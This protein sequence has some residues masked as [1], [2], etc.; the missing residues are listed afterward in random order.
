LHIAYLDV[1]TSGLLRDPEARVVE[2][3]LSVWDGDKEIFR[4]ESLVSGKGPIPEEVSRINGITTEMTVGC[5]TF[6]E[7]YGEWKE[8][9]KKA[10]VVAHNLSFDLGMI[11]RDLIRQ[12]E[13]PLGNPGID[14]LALFRR[15]KPDL[16]SYKLTELVRIMGVLHENPHRAMGDVDAMRG[17]LTRLFEKSLSTHDEG[18]LRMWCGWGGTSAHRYQ[19]DLLSWARDRDMS[20]MIE[21]NF[22]GGLLSWGCVEGKVVSFNGESVLVDTGGNRSVLSLED[23][24]AVYLA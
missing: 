23:V 6:R 22:P 1:E 17:I 2:W 10:I 7:L 21:R 14:S 8:H 9:L 4:G 16:S 24:M 19:R 18:V 15:M 5:P 13:I 11:N 20:V 3:A 12:G